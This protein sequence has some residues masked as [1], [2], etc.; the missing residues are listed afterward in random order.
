MYVV[1]VT[2]HTWFSNRNKQNMCNCNK[3]TWIKCAVY[4]V[5]RRYLAVWLERLTANAVNCPGFDPSILRHSGIWGAAVEA[6]SKIVHKKKN[7]KIQNKFT[8]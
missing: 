4:I 2:V 6:V 1:L 8:S 7:Q 5:S 3:P